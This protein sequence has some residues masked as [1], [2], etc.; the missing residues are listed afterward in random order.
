MARRLNCPPFGFLRASVLASATTS[1]RSSAWDLRLSTFAPV[2]MRL[3]LR[4]AA[5]LATRVV[6]SNSAMV[7]STRNTRIAVGASSMKCVCDDAAMREIPLRL[8]HVV[9]GELDH[10]IAGEPIRALDDDRPRAVAEKPFEHLREAGPVADRTHAVYRR[11]VER[12]DDLI[13][14]R[15]GVAL[16]SDELPFV[17]VLVGADVRAAWRP[18]I[19][20]HRYARLQRRYASNMSAEG[21]PSGPIGSRTQNGRRKQKSGRRKQEVDRNR[22]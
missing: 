20:D 13:A 3:R 4:A 14:R 17:A 10:Q 18:Q 21:E 1:G 5:S 19:G 7:P 12:V 22:R 9:P 11:I 16:D 15:L 6:F 2:A 8:Q